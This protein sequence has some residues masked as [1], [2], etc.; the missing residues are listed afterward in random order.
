MV[1]FHFEEEGITLEVLRNRIVK[2]QTAFVVA[3]VLLC[4]LIVVA[5]VAAIYL[6]KTEDHKSLIVAK[7]FANVTY[8]DYTNFASLVYDA[9]SP[10]TNAYHFDFWAGD[11][12]YAAYSERDLD[13]FLAFAEK[14]PFAPYS[15]E[16]HDCDDFAVE[17][18]GLEVSMW[19]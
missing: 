13:E 6:H 1:S 11:A 3:S 16:N 7:E 2:L 5:C 8:M 18:H 17:L 14:Y 9:V 15:L 10:Y 12:L 4:V 19:I